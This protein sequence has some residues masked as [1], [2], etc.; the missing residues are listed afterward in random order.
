MSAGYLKM[1]RTAMIFLSS[2]A[3]PIILINRK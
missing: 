2:L 3:L 1:P